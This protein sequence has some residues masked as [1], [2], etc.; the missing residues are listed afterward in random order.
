MSDYWFEIQPPE[1]PRNVVV[2]DA[3]A[4]AAGLRPVFGSLIE[5]LAEER[6]AEELPEIAFLGGTRCYSYSEFIRD[7][8]AIFSANAGR[9]R[10]LSPLLEALRDSIPVRVL[11]IAAG[12]IVDLE[13][14]NHTPF[15]ERIAVLRTD[16]SLTI[17]G[18]NRDFD[19]SDLDMAGIARLAC[20]RA[21][22]FRISW[23]GGFPFAWSNSAF[24]FDQGSLVAD[25]MGP[26]ICGWRVPGESD[27]MSP[28][29]EVAW[30]SG[31][32]MRAVVEPAEPMMV[33]EWR[34]FTGAELT[35]LDAWRLRTSAVC[36]RCGGEHT[37]GQ[38]RCLNG[39]LG[40]LP[41][42]RDRPR[43]FARVRVK[44]FQASYQA[45]PNPVAMLGPSSAVVLPIDSSA[46]RWDFDVGRSEWRPGSSFGPFE[47][48]GSDEFL[49]TI[50]GPSPSSE[51]SE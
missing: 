22:R 31:L 10:V 3:S 41:T 44:T 29:A 33:E 30:E 4:A 47:R 34:P 16:P 1:L 11:L 32:V 23:A 19:L 46:I 7:S 21:V 45:T 5:G 12:R 6:S 35:R 50:P 42:L 14:W 9:G 20:L 39:E 8:E 51:G 37:P 13:D 40:V 49:L 17:A 2:L 27:A 28:V 25:E 38:L 18:P 26:V 24:Q 15:A 36:D 43:G 48:F